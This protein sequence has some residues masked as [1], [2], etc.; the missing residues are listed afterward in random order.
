MKADDF[1]DPQT[2]QR[3]S[4]WQAIM[5][6]IWSSENKDAKA[7]VFPAADLKNFHETMNLFARIVGSLAGLSPHDLG[8]TSDNP[9][10]ADAI[11]SGEN[12]LIKR[13]ERRQRMF[14]G[15]WEDAMR[16]VRRI[17][18]GAWEPEAMSLESI[19]RNP[20]TPTIAQSADA[21]VKLHGQGIVPLRQTRQDLGYSPAQIELMEQ[22]DEQEDPMAR[23]GRPAPTPTPPTE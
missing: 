23:L 18:T 2:G 16:L 5:G 7:G 6:R 15:G 4:S 9:A 22:A 8:F 17:Q 3:L 19:W 21:A 1:K 13:A 12:R 20:A 14:G 11:R 10:S